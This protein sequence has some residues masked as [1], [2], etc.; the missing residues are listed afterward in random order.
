MSDHVPSRGAAGVEVRGLT[1]RW[2]RRGAVVPGPAPL[3]D[4]VLESRG[5]SGESAREF[6]DPALRQLHDPSRMPGLD[7]AAERLLEAARAG[8]PIVVYGDYDV[9]GVTATAILYRTL[10]AI[11]P[12]AQLRT[13]VPHRIDEGYGLN[14]AA[15]RALA[16]DGVRVIVSVDCGITAVGPAATARESGVDLIITDHH[17]APS[18]PALLP[19]AFAIVHPRLPGA[20]STYPFGELCGAG[21]AYKLAWRL[22]TMH[23][24]DRRVGEDLREL[25]VELLALAAMGTVADVVPL[26]GEN[27]VLARFGL[28]RCKASPIIGLRALV[29]ASGLDGENID[30]ES[31]GFRLGP[32]LNACGRMGSAADAV[33]LFITEDAERARLIAAELD[34]Q[35]NSRRATERR[36]LEQALRLAEEAGMASDDRRAVV[37]AHADWHPGVVGIVCSRLTERL[38]RPSILLQTQDAEGGPVCVGSGRSIDG[39]NLHAALEACT[40]HLIGFG[41]HDAAA[42]LRLAAHNLDAFTGAFV[43]HANAH[44]TPD[45]LT[46]PAGYDVEASIYELTPRTVGELERLGPFGRDNPSVRIRLDGVR[47]AAPPKCMGQRGAHLDLRLE[48]AG[49]AARRVLRAVAWNWAEQ[50]ECLAAGMPVEAIVAPKLNKWNGSVRCEAELI[51]LRIAE[52]PAIS[53]RTR[54]AE[55]AAV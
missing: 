5:L 32:R 46:R 52:P 47:L 39:F 51:D 42:G 37:L 17:N 11:A 48:D 1:R 6:L 26:V 31:V 20:G 3:V 36:I 40:E 53:V 50:A 22:A 55:S 14:E 41:G 54:A 44:I 25:L 34:T 35:N 9:D 12:D 13:Y 30:A 43:D 19:D 8:E 28:A 7:R 18:N 23:A 21:V 4:R 2:R 38:G 10:R 45:E 29:E 16:A 24:G 33:E 27:R 49:G 15:I